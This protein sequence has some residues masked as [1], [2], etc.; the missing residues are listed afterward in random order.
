[1]KYE[2]QDGEYP[3]TF[4]WTM[5]THDKNFSSL[6]N[7]LNEVC[8]HEY[9]IRFS[10]KEYPVLDVKTQLTT[11]TSL[12]LCNVNLSLKDAADSG[13]FRLLVADDFLVNPKVKELLEDSLIIYRM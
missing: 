4:T 13:L 12:G 3:H 1:M 8:A 9:Q 5:V 10:E 11:F 2:L 7:R 6:R